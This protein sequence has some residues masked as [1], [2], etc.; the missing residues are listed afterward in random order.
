MT[1]Q[2]G[3]NNL[4]VLMHQGMSAADDGQ[5]RDHGNGARIQMPDSNAD[6]PVKL[7]LPLV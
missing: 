4:I 1:S 7:S 2:L 3:A 5:T 6:P